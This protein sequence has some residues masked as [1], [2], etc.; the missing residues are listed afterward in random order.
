[1]IAPEF[2]RQY[3]LCGDP[4]DRSQYQIAVLHEPDGRGGSDLLHRIFAEGRRVF[5][6]KPINHFPLA[7]DASHSILMGGGI[8]ITPMLAMAHALHAQDKSFEL[9]YS[10]RSR[11]TMGFL[12][13]IPKYPWARKAH[14]HISDEGSRVDLAAILGGY[15][16]GWHVYTCGAERFMGSVVDAAT[17]AGFPETACHLEYFSVPETPAYEN[18]DFTLRLTK[19]GKEFLVPPE[20]SA[21]DVL[22]ENGI[23]IDLKCSDGICGVCK[24]GLVSGDVDHRDFVLSKAQRETGIILCQSRA[25]RAGGVVELDM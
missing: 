22:I 14:L 1:M 21:A 3:S 17:Q 18:F 23:H 7:Q 16:T 25:A 12:E 8:G 20:K 9:H 15:E 24:C 6:S 19:S 10:G 2:L 13:E 5:V 4:A 11:A